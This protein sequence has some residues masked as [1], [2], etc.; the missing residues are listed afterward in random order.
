MVCV[1]GIFTP[2]EQQPL[3]SKRLKQGWP[4]AGRKVTCQ[5]IR[6]C[7]ARCLFVP[8][9]PMNSLASCWGE[10]CCEWSMC[11]QR[12]SRSRSASL[13]RARSLGES[14]QKEGGPAFV[15]CTSRS[16]LSKMFEQLQELLVTWQCWRFWFVMKENMVSNAILSSVLT[17]SFL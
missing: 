14:S 2:Q 3:C 10:K 6:K 17:K 1:I 12:C 13:C 9:A 11:A 7:A 5:R 8:I 15:S 4:A 16:V